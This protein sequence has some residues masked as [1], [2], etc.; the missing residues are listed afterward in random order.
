M[1]QIK[2]YLRSASLTDSNVLITGETGTGKERV[3]EL[4]HSHSDR[5][6]RRLISINCAAVPENLLESELFGYEKGAFTGADTAYEGKLK[7]GDGGTVFFDEIGDMSLLAQTKILRAIE[8]KQVYRLGGRKGIVL[9]FRVVAATNRNLEQMIEMGTFRRDLYYRLNVGRIHL[10]PLRER[11]ED[12]P[13]LIRQHLQELNGRLGLK[14]EG[15]NDD[16]MD[17]MLRY[18]WPG[19]IRELKNVLEAALISRPI[20][21]I[22]IAELPQTFCR[23]V[24]EGAGQ[25]S[26]RDTERDSLLAALLS[27][28]WNKSR[29]AKKLNWSRMTVYR[30]MRKYRIPDSDTR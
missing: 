22:G 30:K 14:V 17:L 8:S 21:S 28:N 20:D 11:K 27:S 7:L 23:E 1:S 29:A 18:D 3:A 5:Q 16:A 4:I 12:I 2:D 25:K 24:A 10:P 19:N 9:D 6:D 13:L 26:Q 15:L